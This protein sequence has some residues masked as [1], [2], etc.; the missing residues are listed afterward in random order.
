MA[1]NELL[2]QF[3]QSAGVVCAVL[4]AHV[5]VLRRGTVPIKLSLFCSVQGVALHVRI[6]SGS[7]LCSMSVS[8]PFAPCV[9]RF[10]AFCLFCLWNSC[11]LFGF[12]APVKARLCALSSALIGF[13]VPYDKLAFPSSSI[14]FRICYLAIQLVLTS[15]LFE[16]M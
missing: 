1:L 5:I 12:V 6:F 11:L 16:S 8:R 10:R 3:V 4:H 14:C 2:V 7:V 9:P 13:L 15:Y